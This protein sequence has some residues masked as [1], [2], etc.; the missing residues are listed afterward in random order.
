MIYII[1]K[2]IWQS[3]RNRKTPK[4]EKTQ[5]LLLINIKPVVQYQSIGLSGGELKK[6]T[7]IVPSAT[8]MTSELWRKTDANFL[9]ERGFLFY[10]ITYLIKIMKKKKKNENKI[11]NLK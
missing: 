11:N 9:I 3:G 4:T 7:K 6:P 5:K 10:Q 1:G 2:C 8:N